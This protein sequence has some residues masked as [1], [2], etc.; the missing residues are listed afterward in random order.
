MQQNNI[1]AYFPCFHS[2]IQSSIH[3]F[4]QFHPLIHLRLKYAILFKV[5][6]R[7]IKAKIKQ[8]VIKIRKDASVNILHP[9]LQ[10]CHKKSKNIQCHKNTKKRSD[11]SELWL[12]PLSSLLLLIRA[13]DPSWIMR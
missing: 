8:N 10:K 11:C 1:I 7:I 2:F 9:Y 4:I 6:I 5:K 3:L 12:C 13:T